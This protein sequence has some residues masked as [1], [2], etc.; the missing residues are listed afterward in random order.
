MVYVFLKLKKNGEIHEEISYKHQGSYSL[1][2]QKNYEKQ[3][4]K[5]A[6][7]HGMIRRLNHSTFFLT[8]AVEDA[9]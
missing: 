6:V 9:H 1:N 5:Y 8:G 7:L 2:G 3:S 4:P